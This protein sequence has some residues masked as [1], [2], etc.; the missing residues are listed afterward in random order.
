MEPIEQQVKISPLF[1]GTGACVTDSNI[2]T[3]Y[4]SVMYVVDRKSYK[5]EKEVDLH[6]T[7]TCIYSMNSKIIISTISGILYMYNVREG[8]LEYLIKENLLIKRMIQYR[9]H[10]AAGTSDGLVVLI[11]IEKKGILM[12]KRV[13]GSITAIETT[14]IDGKKRAYLR[15]NGM[16]VVGTTKG[17]VSVID[18]NS[19]NIIY[20]AESH[21]SSV[22]FVEPLGER[23][24]S[25]GDDG[26]L[27][28]HFIGKEPVVTDVGYS[29]SSGV[30]YNGNIIIAGRKNIL[31]YW[32]LDLHRVREE[33]LST[34]LIQSISVHKNELHII[35]EENDVIIAEEKDN[36]TITG[37]IIGDN[38]EI[39]DI[40]I[41]ESHI[42]I[43]TNSRYIRMI[44]KEILNNYGSYACPVMFIESPNEECVLSLASSEKALFCGT[45]DGY[46]LEFVYGENGLP[47]L[48]NSVS[49]TSP[50]TS[51]CFYKDTVISGFEDG[52]IKGWKIDKEFQH[53]FTSVP[54][55]SEITGITVISGTI[56]AASKSK[57]VHRIQFN[58]SVLPGL[59]GH[60][61]GIWSIYESNETLVTT[62]SDKTARLWKQGECQKIFQHNSSVIK[63]CLTSRLVTG[64]SDGV[65]RLW[66]IRKEKELG[67]IKISEKESDRIW[68]IKELLADV[69][70]ISS[71]GSL[72]AIKDN[73]KEI[74]KN[75]EEKE[76]QKYITRQTASSLSRKGF[77]LQAAIEY[78][79]IDM[80]NELK[81]ELKKL[82][83]TTDC[84]L[85]VDEME[86]EKKKSLSLLLQ[87]LRSPALLPI[88]ES[89]L[90]MLLARKWKFEKSIANEL[91]KTL[92]AL[93]ERLHSAY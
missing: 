70:V 66:D 62:S 6:S 59:S 29:I 81:K 61:K 92:T 65:V 3:G 15:G 24:Y 84:S 26:I 13:S 58:G 55:S 5:V 2:F 40:L 52:V 34:P 87:W 63:A 18:V 36:I 72:I 74:E 39:T 19:Q 76:A 21:K 83:I 67:A 14:E 68:S 89:I 51:L 77:H 27:V 49:N 47:V 11:D 50:V 80:K 43:G 30:F 33:K 75:K 60:K 23:I 69:Y 46:I 35:T 57:E 20:Q 12:K 73:T 88:S 71:G 25:G 10:L 45:K 79:K 7:I 38:D 86:K 93:R 64:T 9:E 1:D 31:E 56:L 16:I 82:C 22:S 42:I 85:L 17:E 91:S 37:G 53:V 28:M 44:P 54:S 41:R 8:T 90:K 4:G 48:R 78:F 32:G